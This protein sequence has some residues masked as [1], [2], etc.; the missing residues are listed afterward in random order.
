MLNIKLSLPDI[1]DPVRVSLQRGE[2]LLVGR[3]PS[4]ARLNESLKEA[5]LGLTLRLLPVSSRGVSSNHVLLVQRDDELRIFDLRSRNGTWLRLASEQPV[6]LP[7]AGAVTLEL[8]NLARG[9]HISSGPREAEWTAREEFGGAVTGAINEWL[10]HF[11]RYAEAILL[12]RTP[13]DDSDSMALADGSVLRL[14]FQAALT[15]DLSWRHVQERIRAYVSEQNLRYEQALGHDEDLIL[16][17]PLL[18][19]AHRELADTAAYGIRVMI[20]GPTGSGKE[21]LA[22]CYHLH[23]RQHRGPY[24]AVNCAM[25]EGMLHTQLFGARH[26]VAAETSSDV[27]GLIESAQDG[28]LFLDEVGDMDREVQKSLLRFLDTRGE[29]QLPGEGQS[30]P[31]NVQII[32]ATSLPLDDPEFRRGRFRDDLWYRL[33]VK[34]VRIPPLCERHEDTLAFLRLQTL[35]GSQI[36]V[37]DALSSAA[38]R[39]VLRDALPG[40]FRD[41]ENFVDRLPQSALAGSIDAATCTAALQEG[42]KPQARRSTNEDA[43]PA[44]P[45]A[46]GADWEKLCELALQAF[47][48]DQGAAPKNWGQIN[49]LVEKY[50]KPLFVAHLCDL[51]GSAEIPKATNFSELARRLLLADGSTVKAHLLRYIDRYTRKAPP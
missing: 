8:A 1:Q 3:E 44:A 37:Y 45:A 41:L 48:Q 31:V 9:T 34:V 22:R 18:R 33:G 15:L 30:L 19:Q 29:Y 16:A 27:I 20:L 46:H 4:A 10:Q 42:R 32:C 47:R 12:P 23:S 35:R 39:C 43:P 40:N 25:K 26:G 6:V 7:L 21:R 51:A 13:L 38:L 11:A 24:V 5:L 17:S 50:L 36:R 14:Q 28:T 2:A 49:A